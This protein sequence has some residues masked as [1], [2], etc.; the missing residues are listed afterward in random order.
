MEAIRISETSGNFNVTTARY[1]PENSKL[2]LVIFFLIAPFENVWRLEGHGISTRNGLT[3]LS[4]KS[5]TTFTFCLM[6]F[7]G[8]AENSTFIFSCLIYV[9]KFIL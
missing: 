2:R 9:P 6:N 7:V 1:I 8:A 4:V 3:T 5:C